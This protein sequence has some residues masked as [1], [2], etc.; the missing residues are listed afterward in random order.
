MQHALTHAEATG[1]PLR[2]RPRRRPIEVALVNNMPDAALLATER[3]FAGL[4]AEAAGEAFD[5]T[6]RL[7][8]LAAVPRGELARASMQDRY[9]GIDALK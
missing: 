6:L 8:A 7:Y 9:A 5:V 3:Q 2:P 4:L 1:R